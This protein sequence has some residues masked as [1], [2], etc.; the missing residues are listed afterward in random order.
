MMKKNFYLTMG[1]WVAWS[2]P[3][4]FAQSLTVANDSAANYSSWNSGDNL[5]KG[6]GPWTLEANNGG[7]FIGDP[8]GRASNLSGSFT[9]SGK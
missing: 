5:G 9:T 7:T 8:S 4:L 6:F 1:L 3:H 2:A